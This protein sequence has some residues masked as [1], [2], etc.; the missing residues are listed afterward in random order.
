MLKSHEFP[1]CL[2]SFVCSKEAVLSLGVMFE[3]S[4]PENFSFLE[5]YRCSKGDKEGLRE[6]V[7]ETNIRQ[8][9]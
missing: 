5:Q 7:Q 4:T 3:R 6:R 1:E 9:D 2:Y 8:T